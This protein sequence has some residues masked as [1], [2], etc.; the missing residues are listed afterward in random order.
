MAGN[1]AIGESVLLLDNFS[2]D[3]QDLYQSFRRAENKIPAAVINDEGFL[4][5]DII[6]VYG[7]FLGD[8]KGVQ[9]EAAGPRYFNEIIVP[10]Y[11][12][13]SGTN[14]M[15]KIHDLYRERGKIFYAEPKH[16][17]LVKVVDWYDEKGV[18]RFSDHYNCYGALYARTVFNAKGQRFSKSYFSPE[19]Y[20]IIVENYVTGDVIL[21]EDGKMHFF[22][23]KTDF[24]VYFLKKTG[25][26]RNRILFNSLST[27]FFVSQK[28]EGS[29]KRDVLFWQEPIGEEIPGNMQIILNGQASRTASIIV[30]K[31]SAYD[32]LLA[33]GAKK[34]QIRRM[35]FCYS[36]ARDNAH[37]AE[38]LI[39]TNSD[40]IEHCRELVEALPEMNFH[41]VALTEMS[42]KLME[43]GVYSNVSLYPGVKMS[44]LDELFEKCDYY[45]D[46]NYEAEIV[47]A[48]RRAFIQNQ[49]IFAFQETIHNRDFVAEEHIYKAE[50]AKQMIEAI[51]TV[52]DGREKMEDHLKFQ[53]KMAMA[54]RA[55]VYLKI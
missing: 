37:K 48:V 42:S 13:I 8:F 35:G 22:S 1:F 11:W 27:P 54:E 19:G 18:V 26:F 24:V 3:S 21:N 34:D 39:C 9:G 33:L 6:S 20:E 32:K 16:R 44:V 41:I 49:L 38:A 55:E 53:H 46:I 43:M 40:H 51:R 45:L 14:S 28:L 31:R 47:S 7:F 23:T 17:R 5:E 15:G 25:L 2:I 52:M 4:P 29:E 10:D 36:F 30:Q 12:E 50:E